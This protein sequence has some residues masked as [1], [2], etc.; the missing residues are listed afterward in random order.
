MNKKLMFGLAVIALILLGYFALQNDNTQTSNSQSPMTMESMGMDQVSDSGL[1][2]VKDNVDLQF[3]KDYSINDEWKVKV[4]QFEPNAKIND[5]GIIVSDS[6]EE[7]NPAV[8][9]NFYKNDEL[10]HYQICFKEMPGFHSVKEGQ[11]YLIDLI[12]YDG[13]K[14]SDNGNYTISSINAK[15]WRIK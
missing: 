2:L 6:D 7:L 5:P 12:N 3:N 1:E 15:I 9:I 14:K 13:F 10:I 4:I 11:N 8:K